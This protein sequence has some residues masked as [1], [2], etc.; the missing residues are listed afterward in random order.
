MILVGED[1]SSSA[2]GIAVS[3]AGRS[4]AVKRGIYL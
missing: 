1:V 2:L 4:V 3:L